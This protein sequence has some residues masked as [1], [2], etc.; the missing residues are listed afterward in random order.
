MGG[1][2]DA[3]RPGAQRCNKALYRI[4]NPETN[5][6]WYVQGR[7]TTPICCTGWVAGFVFEGGDFSLS[8]LEESLCT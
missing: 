4:Y 1:A 2:A 8:E 5:W 3:G 7:A 6:I